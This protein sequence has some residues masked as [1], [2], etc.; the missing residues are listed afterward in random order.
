MNFTDENSPDRKPTPVDEVA[1]D[2]ELNNLLGAWS[3]PEVPGSLDQR[4]LMTYRRQFHHKSF[5]R[6]WLTGSINLPAPVAVTMALL[7]CAASF[8]AIR[9][10]TSYSIDV[11]PSPPVMKLI[12]VPLPVIR[13]KIMTRV[14][15]KQTGAQKNK[16]SPQ[17]TP[18]PPRIDLANFRPVG[19]IKLIVIPGGNDEK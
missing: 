13:T 14:V 1:E 6:R 19:E 3:V 18:L 9:N 15:Y 2:S 16:V 17:P 5:W 10:T 7:L 12:E 4:I 11:P 8:L